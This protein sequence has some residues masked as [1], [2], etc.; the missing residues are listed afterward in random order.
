MCYRLSNFCCFLQ[1]I[2]FRL[3]SGLPAVV[4][5]LG[6]LL[7]FAT[8]PVV[9]DDWVEYRSEHF[10]VFTDSPADDARQYLHHAEQF[11][12]VLSRFMPLHDSISLKLVLYSNNSMFRSL[13]NQDLAGVLLPPSDDEQF[14]LLDAT[15]EQRLQNAG[16]YHLYTQYQLQD[17]GAD[18]P[19]W[20]RMALVELLSATRL[21]EGNALVGVTNQM[22]RGTA[23]QLIAINALLQLHRASHTNEQRHHLWALGHFLL[24]GKLAGATDYTAATVKYLRMRREGESDDTAFVTAFGKS[25]EAMSSELNAYIHSSALKAA[26]VPLQPYDGEVAIR[27]LPDP[28]VQLLLGRIALLANQPELAVQHLQKI[29]QGADGFL[30]SQQLL[31]S[32]ALV[33]QGRKNALNNAAQPGKNAEQQRVLSS[34]ITEL[35][36]QLKQK[37][38]D[39]SLL[40]ELAGH[41]KQ[42]AVLAKDASQHQ[43]RMQQAINYA[44]QSL[45]LKPAQQ[46]M[47]S[48][49][50]VSY[51]SIG[52]REK[53]FV[54]LEAMQ[55]MEPE[56][57][58]LKL[59]VGRFLFNDR[60]YQQAL[61]YLK[62]AE[63]YAGCKALCQQDLAD[64]LQ[65]IQQKTAKP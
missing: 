28:E 57:I 20:F 22:T 39:V 60:K 35:E 36:Q 18:Y 27:V 40:A 15:K 45:Q 55:Q 33:I 63:N 37:P 54:H 61:P 52:K 16:L 12:Q 62:A 10:I 9:A 38:Q 11:R 4:Q 21:E 8:A 5:V 31:K 44:E 56:N 30:P 53:A 17:S 58:M 13:V 48:L 50:Y 6:G 47:H 19:Y 46:D 49:L 51:K 41:Y 32:A 59:S 65:K 29:P 2:F 34:R 14:M 3:C 24:L 26:V 7:C 25:P 1:K 42:L 43:K 23:S 64:K